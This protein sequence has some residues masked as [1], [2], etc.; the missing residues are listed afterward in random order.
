MNISKVLNVIPYQFD[1]FIS[2]SDDR[3]IK[4]WSIE[5]NECLKK[6]KCE[7]AANYISLSFNQ[8]TL[9]S[10]HSIGDDNTIIQ[11]LNLENDSPPKSHL[12]TDIN[13]NA[14]KFFYPLS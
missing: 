4:I 3:T 1:K 11:T 2:F 7:S 5:A 6:L 9:L 13:K 8:T 14:F 10:F 12:L